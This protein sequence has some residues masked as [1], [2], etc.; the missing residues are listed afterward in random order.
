M[1]QGPETVFDRPPA[2]ILPALAGAKAT[3][4]N[5][6]VGPEL[7]F[8][9]YR[10]GRWPARVFLRVREAARASIVRRAC[11]AI[12]PATTTV[13]ETREASGNDGPPQLPQRRNR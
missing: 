6:R 7:V 4:E 12:C 10:A 11:R 1:K 3:G 8:W 2:E 5:G 13:L 9:G